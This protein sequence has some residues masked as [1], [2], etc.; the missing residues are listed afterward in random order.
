MGASFK[1]TNRQAWDNYIAVMLDPTTP[2]GLNLTEIINLGHARCVSQQIFHT[3]PNSDLP[4]GSKGNKWARKNQ[5]FM[6]YFRNYESRGISK[7]DKR[8]SFGMLN[9]HYQNMIVGQAQMEKVIQCVVEM[10]A[11]CIVP[12][13]RIVKWA[14]RMSFLPLLDSKYSF[15]RTTSQGSIGLKDKPLGISDLA[16]TYAALEKSETKDKPSTQ[17]ESYH[18]DNALFMPNAAGFKPYTLNFSPKIIQT[19]E[20]INL[21]RKG[22]AITDEIDAHHREELYKALSNK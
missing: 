22:D 11:L 4:E 16:I 1:E 3:N 6:E 7:E 14:A 21:K 17:W 13:F 15:L 2:A 8:F 9:D 5:E 19:I 12:T 18:V 20:G 10:N